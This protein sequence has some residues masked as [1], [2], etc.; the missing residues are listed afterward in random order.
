[1]RGWEVWGLGGPTS[2]T[3]TVI[4][5]SQEL[6]YIIQN[7]KQTP[8]SSY[9]IQWTERTERGNT[10]QFIV[11]LIQPA[12]SEGRCCGWTVD[13]GHEDMTMWLQMLTM[14]WLMSVLIG[15][16]LI[17]PLLA[18]RL[19]NS[20]LYDPVSFK[21]HHNRTSTFSLCHT[22]FISRCPCGP[23]LPPTGLT[24]LGRKTCLPPL[25]PPGSC[26]I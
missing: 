7:R 5:V 13:T 20:Q 16:I 11:L 18:R 24:P 6:S 14:L 19:E 1:M 21:S 17:V 9:L 2:V 3:E 26:N 8:A 4:S 10:L 15:T 23:Q 22:N 25:T 12:A